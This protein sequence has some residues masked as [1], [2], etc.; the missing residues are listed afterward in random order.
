MNRKERIK[1]KKNRG[2]EREGE[3]T[4]PIVSPFATNLS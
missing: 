1:N 2:K 3:K 4:C